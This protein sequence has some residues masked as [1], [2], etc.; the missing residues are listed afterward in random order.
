MKSMKQLETERFMNE[1]F[2]C[3]MNEVVDKKNV[4]IQVIPVTSVIFNNVEPIDYHA[5]SSVNDLAWYYDGEFISID[6]C[7]SLHRYIE[8]FEEVLNLFPK[9][10]LINKPTYVYLKGFIGFNSVDY[11][12]VCIVHKYESDLNS[13]PMKSFRQQ[14]WV[15]GGLVGCLGADN[16]NGLYWKESNI[17]MALKLINYITWV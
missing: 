5:I 10:E 14:H 7:L 13:L 12:Y 16:A 3:K 1:P 15:T 4:D 11:R 8:N 2:R 6:S 17:K 9:A